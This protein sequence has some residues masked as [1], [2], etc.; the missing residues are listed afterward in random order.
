MEQKGEYMKGVGPETIE[1][2]RKIDRGE[3]HQIP[4]AP[5]RNF[6]PFLFSNNLATS[7]GKGNYVLTIDGK[8]LLDEIE[9]KEA[10][11]KRFNRHTFDPVGNYEDR[12]RLRQLRQ[13][14]YSRRHAYS[15]SKKESG[16]F[17]AFN[18]HASSGPMAVLNRLAMTGR[19]QGTFLDIG[20]GDSADAI[21][22]TAL[23][24]KGLGLDL[25][26]P[27]EKDGNG[28]TFKGCDRVEFIQADAAER[29]PLPGNSVIGASAYAM[30]NLI[31]PEARGKFYDEVF[32]V[33][34]PGG[35]FYLKVFTLKLAHR[36]SHR[37]EGERMEQAG[38]KVEF[39]HSN[40]YVLEA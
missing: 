26:P 2:M 27:R 22:A 11:V 10:T 33:L 21:I 15:Y 20:C 9:K 4:S 28:R 16:F 18:R 25:F 23:G 37:E 38:F 29:I 8:L 39:T 7:I 32:R 1:F 30:A 34:Q 40:S 12:E 14:G 36:W 31:E 19:Y 3:V 13:R 6:M 35:L 17:T 5:N 24:Y